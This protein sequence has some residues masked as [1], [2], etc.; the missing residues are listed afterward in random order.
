MPF[1]RSRRS[2]PPDPRQAGA[3]DPQD[4]RLTFE[5]VVAGI[6]DYAIC[7]LDPEGRVTSWN[8]G[9]E[10]IEGFRQNEVQGRHISLIYPEDAVSRGSPDDELKIAAASGR[11]ETDGWRL[12]KDGSTYWAN[13]VL[14]PI[15]D[16]KTGVQGFV[17]IIRDLTDRK[18]AEEAL[19]R[20][21]ERFR[22]MVEGARDYAM[23][24]LDPQG[25]VR[26]WNV[27]AE[28]IKG[29][30]ANEIIGRHFSVFYT[31]EAVQKG[32]PQHELQVARNVGRFEDEGLR[33]RK[34]G[35]TFWGNVIITAIFD[36]AGELQGFSKL[37]RDLTDRR[38]ADEAIRE[39]NQNLE[40]RVEER[41]RELTLLA[42][43]LKTEVAERA[44]L[45]EELRRRM[46]ELNQAD[47]QKNTF[48]AML[49]HELRNPLAPIRNALYLLDARNL[50][51][52]EVAGATRLIGRQVDQMV[53][54][55]NDLLDVSRI[56]QN[57]I[58]LHTERLDVSE[59]IRR[60]VETA[61]P[62]IAARGHRLEVHLPDQA[63]TLEGDMVRLS[64]AFGNLLLN[65]AKYTEEGGRISVRVE[66]TDA[67]A[68]VRV[69]DTG[70][71]IEPEMLERVFDLFTQSGI[72]LA[73]TEGGLGI[74][75]TLVR[76][77]VQM[78]GGAVE[79]RSDGV[80]RGSEFIV[81]L[82]I[83]QAPR[84]QI[85]QEVDQ[86]T[87]TSH[88]RR[89]LVVDDNLDAADSLASLLSLLGHDVQV[90]Y[91]GP[92]ALD[93]VVR[94]HPEVVLLDIGLPGMDRYEVARRLRKTMGQ[95]TVAL[96]ALTG[97]GQAEDRQRAYE[98][99]FDHHLTKPVDPQSL[100]TLIAG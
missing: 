59:A 73:R 44:R 36:K 54:L 34:D 55:V 18:Q 50:S 86:L 47:T 20:S 64:Q 14:T 31:Q 21:E 2:T 93:A 58:E 26:T 71:G 94:E 7:L 48:L 49:S 88:P 98:A 69:K 40:R 10:R 70:I 78:H 51:Q 75:L 57:R 76:R 43:S 74:G 30:K 99:G 22:L 46:L 79:A 100:A 52:E 42:D 1:R 17:L 16:G 28:R 5:H 41:T 32:W 23:F 3:S 91:D 45:T 39:S 33:V 87:S 96:I 62:V 24:M 4:T 65:A 61:E 9:A 68:V 37:T 97:Y 29:Y 13:V 67:G 81:R 63:V 90:A 92:S 77:I 84:R 35:T 15:K 56:V 95:H 6:H 89:V 72:T 53:R 80:G 38:K 85:H 11:F 83:S 60:A 25:H 8:A 27:G 66:R 82:P 19:R 12:R